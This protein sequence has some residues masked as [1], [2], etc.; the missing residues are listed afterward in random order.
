MK[1]LIA[2]DLHFEYYIRDKWKKFV[3]KM[4]EADVLV[5]PGD[6]ATSSFIT[7]ALVVLLKKYKDVVFVAG[8]HEFYGSSIDAVKAEIRSLEAD[9]LDWGD[10]K[11]LGR[12]HF[13]DND[14]CTIGNHRF[15]G[16][17][18]WFPYDRG[19]LESHGRKLDDF[20]KIE[21]AKKTIYEENEKGVAF[22]RKEVLHG[23]IVVT[24]HLPSYLS[25]HPA[26]AGHPSNGFFVCDMENLIEG[27]APKVWI[28]G[29]T[30]TS[31]DYEIGK[32]RVVCNPF[33][34]VGHTL[35]NKFNN[36]LIIEI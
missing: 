28:H 17:T 30:H 4:P 27:V 29:H 20:S 2:S 33:G 19:L 35:N 14:T 1:I 16:S 10:G 31:C 3:D 11:G 34:Y 24:H 5:C 36:D 18:M 21:D 9:V 13:L 23:D 6:L 25:V 32:T 15:I 8:N 26:Y 22:L 7:L 12:L